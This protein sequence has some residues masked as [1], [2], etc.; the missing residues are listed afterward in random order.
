M[1]RMQGAFSPV[2]LA[3]L[4]LSGCTQSIA[5]ESYE[6]VP[7][8]AELSLDR[9]IVASWVSSEGGDLAVSMYMSSSCPTVPTK[10]EVEDDRVVLIE[11][12]RQGLMCTSDQE[13]GTF[14]VA[15]PDVELSGELAVVVKFNGESYPVELLAAH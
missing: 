14:V 4:L 12:T 11:V 15:V 10:V 1:T 2:A 7:P 6:G 8:G 13:A 9:E 5:I 3:V